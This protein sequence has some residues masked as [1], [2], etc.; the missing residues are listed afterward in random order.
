MV[1][2]LEPYKSTS[3]IL[4]SHRNRTNGHKH[5]AQRALAPGAVAFA[6]TASS[7]GCT[8]Q[9]CTVKRATFGFLCRAE[10]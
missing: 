9:L 5:D 4:A 6:L 7:P 3:S 2:A 1:Q 8:A 10:V